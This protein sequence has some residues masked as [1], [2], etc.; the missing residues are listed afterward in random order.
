MMETE[1][2]IIKEKEEEEDEIQE[3]NFVD[4]FELENIKKKIES[5]NKLHHIEILKILKTCSNIK[6]NENKSGIF[7]N[8]SFL[9]KSILDEIKKYIDYIQV[10][11]S[12]IS[13]LETRCDEFKNTFF[14]DKE[15]KDNT[16]MYNRTTSVLQ[17]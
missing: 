17:N 2:I 3:E 10:Q 6:I 9:P 16:I 8:L 13:Q 4:T 14:I 12:S 7:V 5:M 15:D 1:E 11:E